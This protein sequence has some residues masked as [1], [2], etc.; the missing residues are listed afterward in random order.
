[1]LCEKCGTQNEEGRATCTN[2]GTA[3]TEEQEPPKKKGSFGKVMLLLVAVAVALWAAVFMSGALGGGKSTP[4]AAANYIAEAMLAG[5]TQKVASMIPDGGWQVIKD[6]YGIESKEAFKE[7]LNEGLSE[8]RELKS[9]GVKMTCVS[10]NLWTNSLYSWQAEELRK[11]GI[12]ATET[13]NAAVDVLLTYQ[14]ESEQGTL[15][16]PLI[17]IGEKWYLDFSSL[18]YLDTF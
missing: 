8:I 9:K 14:G 2:C 12:A 3:L 1:M 5:D 13:C 17:Q 18:N 11:A 16:I 10:A 4:E 15:R 7:Q 6:T